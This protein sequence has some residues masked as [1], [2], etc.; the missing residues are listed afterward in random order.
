MLILAATGA[1]TLSIRADTQSDLKLV[2][3]PAEITAP[4]AAGI[5]GTEQVAIDIYNQ[6]NHL[7]ELPNN[8][9][10]VIERSDTP[11][12]PC[13]TPLAPY[14]PLILAPGD[15]VRVVWRLREPTDV[16][17]ASG[18]TAGPAKVAAGT[19]NVFVFYR[20]PGEQV[21]RRHTATVEL[22]AISWTWTIVA[23]VAALLLILGSIA[24]YNSD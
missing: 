19:H 1:F 21:W 7:L 24:L 8:R 13:F 15:K 20:A 11:D 6:S 18:S 16:Y 9:W 17:L 22:Q 5:A 2:F 3:T 10:L 14:A 4:F 12:A 23:A